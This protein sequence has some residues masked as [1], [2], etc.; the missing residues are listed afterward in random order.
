MAPEEDA[1]KGLAPEELVRCN[2]CGPVYTGAVVRAEQ[3]HPA[4]TD[5][6]CECGN[7]EFDVVTNRDES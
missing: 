2:E 5:G 7:E 3:V 6:K 1:E 4:G